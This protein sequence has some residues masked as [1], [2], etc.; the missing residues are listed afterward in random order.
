MSVR[1]YV[2][3]CL[4]AGT[5]VCALYIYI[6][7]MHVCACLYVFVGVWRDVHVCLCPCSGGRKNE[8]EAFCY[9][10]HI[11]KMVSSLK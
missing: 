2:S 7:G 9:Q 10:M 3:V 4:C 8:K 5:Y 11:N 6:C 1:F